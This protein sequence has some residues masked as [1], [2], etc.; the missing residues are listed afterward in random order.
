MV[1]RRRRRVN[2]QEGQPRRWV[3]VALGL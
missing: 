3:G 1:A 2:G